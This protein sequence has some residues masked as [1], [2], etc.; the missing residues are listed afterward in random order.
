M[1]LYHINF[2]AENSCQ[3]DVCVSLLAMVIAAGGAA[4]ITTL[5]SASY[6]KTNSSA[7]TGKRLALQKFLRI[8]LWLIY[9]VLRLPSSSDTVSSFF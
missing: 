2:L 9:C 1:A 6:V 4:D 8:A 3:Q 7:A 5:D